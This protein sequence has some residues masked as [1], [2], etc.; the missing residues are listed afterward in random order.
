ML[1]NTHKYLFTL[2]L[3]TVV[4]HILQAQAWTLQQCVDTALINNRSLLMARNQTDIGDQK[5]REAKANLIPKLTVNAD[6]KYFTDLPTQLMPL[7]TFNPAAPEGQFKE[8]QF[9]VPHNMGATVQLSMPLYNPQVMGAIATTKMAKELTALQYRKSE[10]QVWLEVT[11]LYYTAQIIDYQIHFLDSNIINNQRLVKNIQLLKE[12]LMAKGTDVN[13]VQLQLAQLHTQRATAASKYEQ[14]LNALKF[15]MGI[16]L[17]QPISIDTR[18]GYDTPDEYPLNNPIELQIAQM[19]QKMAAK[20]LSNTRKSRLPSIGL[21]ASYG[22][23]GFGYDKSPNDFLKFF[24]VG[25][26]GIQLS[27]PLFAG[28][29]TQHKINQKKVELK[30]STLQQSMAEE[31]NKMQIANASSQR[32]VALQSISNTTAQI[33]QA[34]NIY[35]QTL[36]QQQQGVASLADVLLA[37]TALREAQQNHLSAVVDYLK[38][39]TELKKFTGSLIK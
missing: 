16:S 39:D 17:E 35:R 11:N 31:Q 25:F 32:T 34:D 27:Y 5:H 3:L 36:L 18:I 21:V 2:L 14:V 30:N 22:T 8:A 6:Y 7:S 10:E 19:Q 33:A 24:P 9:G 29:V 28:T 13:K 38:A 12:Q 23:A 26:A 15:T 4:V 20:E 1:V 37:D